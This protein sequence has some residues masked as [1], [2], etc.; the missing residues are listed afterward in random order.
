MSRE[1]ADPQ[2]ILV[3]TLA[4]LGDALL[5]IPA[6][7]ALRDAY[8]TA[9]IDVLTTAL[10]ATTI[11]L[12]AVCDDLILFEKQRFNR[13]RG[14]IDRNNLRYAFGLWRR[15]RHT[16]YDTC[17]LL[18][19]LTTR[20]GTAKYA[21]LT[22]ASGAARRYGLD[23]G[24]GWFLTD[25]VRDAGFGARHQSQYW[26]DVVGLLGAHTW[27]DAPLM[28]DS[29]AE[30]TAISLPDEPPD[31]PWIALHAGSGAFAPA[32]RW[33][34]DRWAALADALIEDGAAIVLV[35]GA[36]EADLRRSLLGAMRHAEHAIDLG[37]R[38][39]I[40]ELAA[41]LRRCALFVGND[42][43]LAHL[44]SA[45]GTPTVTV[46]GPTD[47]RAWGPSRGT[48]WQPVDQRENGVE[49]LASQ[50]H[51]SIKAAIACSPCVYRGHALGT[52]QGCPDR[53]CL[54][55]I[56]VE[57]TLAL[58]RQRI[59]ELNIQC[60]STTSSTSRSATTASMP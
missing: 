2:R 45:A 10:G 57:Q 39:S 49:I 41:V 53:T 28:L 7:R 50:E 5:T 51:R 33:P 42:S 55:R 1:T 29:V 21:A 4:D 59:R 8:P 19:H 13:V 9:Q 46:F 12:A 34:L 6:L 32:R 38:T 30:P 60:A 20:F 37:G 17:V 56:T 22:L 14:L 44:A 48:A 47:P 27:P 23:N 52:P 25:R 40:A 26:L 35:G 43:G 11:R 54:N 58:V 16:R 36:E 18:H 15:L 3:V 31:R 24:R